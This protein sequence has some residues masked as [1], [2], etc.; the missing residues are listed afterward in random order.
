M[1]QLHDSALNLYNQYYEVRRKLN[2]VSA[3]YWT[4]LEIFGW[5]NQAQLFIA[6]KSKCLKRTATITTTA[7]TSEYDLNSTTNGFTDIIDISDDGVYFYV[8]GTTYLPL[9]FAT[10][11]RLNKE[12]P[13]W[14][15]I[16][17]SVPKNYY[18]DKATKTIGIFPKPNTANAGAYLFVSG[19]HK[20]KVLHAGTCV[21]G[22]GTTALV[23]QA[24]S[25]TYPYPN[26]TNDYYNNLYVE[27]YSGTGAGQKVKITDY[28]GSSVTCTLAFTTAPDTNSIYGLVP[29]IPEDAHYL[30]PLYAIARAFE[31]GGSRTN[32]ANNYWTQFNGGLLLFM[33]EMIDDD[34]DTISRDTYR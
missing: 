30:M 19:Y 28:V 11:G 10:K 25:T 16:A 33:G 15:G 18:Y 6:K 27:I 23:L 34:D 4:D 20:P 12:N 22:T 1:P 5:L 21:T 9:T 24:G 32:L 13:G 7:S 17:A 26:P 14:Q 2:E 3:S 29:Q 8:N 31:K